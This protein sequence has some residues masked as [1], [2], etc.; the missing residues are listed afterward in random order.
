MKIRAKISKMSWLIV[1]LTLP[2]LGADALNRGQVSQTQQATTIYGNIPI[3][4]PYAQLKQKLGNIESEKSNFKP[5]AEKHQFFTDELCRLFGVSSH[6]VYTNKVDFKLQT[7]VGRDDGHY[8]GEIVCRA[9]PYLIQ[10][11]ATEYV[12]LLTAGDFI[13]KYQTELKTK[14]K[15]AQIVSLPDIK[16]AHNGLNDFKNI[17]SYVMVLDDG[18][19]ACFKYGLLNEDKGR[20]MDVGRFIFFGK[21]KRDE[22]LP[23]LTKFQKP[24]L[25][26]VGS[27]IAKNGVAID[28]VSINLPYEQL[29][30]ELAKKFGGIKEEETNELLEGTSTFFTEEL[31]KLFGCAVNPIS[32]KIVR[33]NTRGVTLWQENGT[34][35]VVVSNAAGI[36]EGF[37]NVVNATRALQ[38]KYN[39][40]ETVTL[41]YIAKASSD[42][43]ITYNDIK[44]FMM[45]LDDGIIVCSRC[46][47]N[48]SAKALSLRRSPRTLYLGRFVYFDKS[49]R[50]EIV[51][52]LKNRK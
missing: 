28:G 14:Y 1:C 34:K 46:E 2:L 4:L 42:P 38:S 33:Y 11:N 41:P 47:M 3:N 40:A 16:E 26:P 13:R 23:R 49:K 37:M 45:I 20:Y 39:D 8:P 44:S 52:R 50:D 25:Q 36:P 17:E 19:I 32:Q 43:V 24:T 31:C 15:K 6:P 18:L 10:E 27:K 35:Y 22:I 5:E 7:L 9:I 21:S 29:K 12:V 30:Q 48:F 51:T